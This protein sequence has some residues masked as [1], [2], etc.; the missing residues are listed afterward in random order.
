[1]KLEPYFISLSKINWRESKD[2][3]VRPETIK[4]SEENTEKMIPDMGHGNDFFLIWHI[5]QATK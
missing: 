5:K 4:L 1:M 3:T 2:L